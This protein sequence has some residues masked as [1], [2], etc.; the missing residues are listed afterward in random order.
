MVVSL[1]WKKRHMISQD[2]SAVDRRSCLQ[3]E[4]FFLIKRRD[5]A[6]TWHVIAK[7]CPNCKLKY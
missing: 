7:L 2:Y 6:P 4:W 3:S 5:V 1:L